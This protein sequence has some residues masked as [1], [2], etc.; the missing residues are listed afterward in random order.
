MLIWKLNDY[1]SSNKMI[2]SDKEKIDIKAKYWYNLL[3]IY[4]YIK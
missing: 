3:L 4:I 2:M 1:N